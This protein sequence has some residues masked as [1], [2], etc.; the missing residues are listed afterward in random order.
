MFL[1]LELWLKKRCKKGERGELLFSFE[2][3]Q[4]DENH[5]YFLGINI[6]HYIVERRTFFTKV[7]M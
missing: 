7:L 6:N 2:G 3:D 4:T 1:L 5:F